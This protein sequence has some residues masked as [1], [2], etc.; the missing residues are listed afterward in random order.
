MLPTGR[1]R[2][3]RR[4]HFAAV[5]GAFAFTWF[6]AGC[7]DP[8]APVFDS[9]TTEEP[10]TPP[11]AFGVASTSPSNGEQDVARNRPIRITL[12]AAA[13]VPSL[14]SA[15]TVTGASGV[16]S[17]DSASR[18]AVFTPAGLYGPGSSISVVV[19]TALKDA[20]GRPLAADYSF[21]F[22]VSNDA[23][24]PQVVSTV[25]ANGAVDA[26]GIA[27][28]RAVFDE[29]L[30][31]TTVTTSSFTV[32]GADGGVSYDVAGRTAI[33]TPA[34]PLPLGTV[35]TASLSSGIR[36]LNGNP[37]A[38]GHRWSFTTEPD[39]YPPS[40]LFFDPLEG[41]G[42][43]SPGAPVLVRFDE[44][45][46]SAL[47]N[48]TNFTLRQ[49][50][51]GSVSG[52]VY[53]DTQEHSVSFT[54]YSDLEI[55]R[56][57]TARLA[58]G[59][60]RDLAG[61]TF[62]TELSWSFTTAADTTP[63]RVVSSSPANGAQGVA[64]SAGLAVVFNE[65]LDPGWVS[66]AFTVT[67]D[68][69]S[70]LPGS[71][72]Y[73]ASSRTATFRPYAEFALSTQYTL[74]V[75][76]AVRD[77]S[78]NRL[79]TP[80]VVSFRTE[81]DLI[82]PTVTGFSPGPGD[83]LVG[84]NA[85]ATVTFSEPVD[86]LT[87]LT[88]FRVEGVD[89]GVVYDPLQRRATFTPHER[90]TPGRSYLARVTSGVVDRAGNAL[91]PPQTFTF[92]TVPAPQLVS[93]VTASAHQD[94]LL[95]FSPSGEG[96]AAWR[97][98]NGGN[99]VT[100]AAHH[101]A[102]AGWQ[103]EE[104]MAIGGGIPTLKSSGAQATLGGTYGLRFND[105]G[106]GW[107][108]TEGFDTA[109]PIPGP[110]GFL[111]LRREGGGLT[112]TVLSNGVQTAPELLEGGAPQYWA[113]ATRTGYAIVYLSDG[114]ISGR[115]FAGGSWSAPSVLGTTLLADGGTRSLL[116]LKL[117][118][119]GTGLVAAWT[120][121]EAGDFRV[122]LVTH[123]GIAWS[124]AQEFG[125]SQS[126]DSALA[127]SE[128]THL[129][130]LQS[131]FTF[132]PPQ[133]L[134]HRGGAW[135]DA[136]SVPINGYLDS[137]TLVASADRYAALTY[138]SALVFLDGGW[139]GAT[140]LPDRVGPFAVQQ[141]VGNEVGFSVVF[142]ND[143]GLS[144][145]RY[146]DGAWG[147]DVV[148]ATASHPLEEFSLLGAGR[149]LVLGWEGDDNVHVRKTSGGAWQPPVTLPT[150]S[151]AGTVDAPE[152]VGD[153]AGRAAAVWGQWAGRKRGLYGNVFD[154]A[155]WGT[156]FLLAAE[157]NAV[158]VGSNGSSFLFA[159]GERVVND[160]FQIATRRFTQSLQPLVQIPTD[161]G[162]YPVDLE[163]AS[164]GTG[165][166]VAWADSRAVSAAISED[167]VSFGPKAHVIL[168]DH[169][170]VKLASNG[171]TYGA[172]VR[173]YAGSILS[174]VLHDG[175]QWGAATSFGSTSDDFDFAGAPAGYAVLWG[176]WLSSSTGSVA[177]SPGAG[178][179]WDIRSLAGS[180][181]VGPG[182][183]TRV[184]SGLFAFQR[185][186]QGARYVPITSAGIGTIGTLSP[187]PYFSDVASIGGGFAFL[188]GTYDRQ[189]VSL[190]AR[191]SATL[192]ALSPLGLI[193]DHDATIDEAR[194]RANYDH[195][196]VSWLE[197]DPLRVG[198]LWVQ[199]GL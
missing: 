77:A 1:D 148:L 150:R 73:S 170:T 86:P 59:A 40:V 114:A 182:R 147:T 187:D 185:S 139:G 196:L 192:P 108:S 87:V 66:G 14:S 144:E 83:R 107:S 157:G 115:V 33:F 143:G 162:F 161:A 103:P 41:A 11:A 21:G 57:Y 160:T 145:R 60:V 65:A 120:T 198:R 184:G 82:P 117:S 53:V 97:V 152:V 63:P 134:L 149:E 96:Y 129:L 50:D 169:E 54:P 127:S 109:D 156:P 36:D 177:F 52:S 78:G 155:S 119:G 38:G 42:N 128:T 111:F 6:G 153:S 37:L 89:G 112:A 9:G 55:G 166:A 135:S 100:V 159:Y 158:S 102:D 28:L 189:L 23:T 141:L 12:N 3:M 167:G 4:S 104:V 142:S 91:S 93:G 137:T 101:V 133:Y 81:A 154:G 35:V 174:T 31:P 75:S 27:P 116:N 178:A 79:A 39:V 64:T 110:N 17:W 126:F 26:G 43:A 123:D 16:I 190:G 20:A 168:G 10:P 183:L 175:G 138:R 151:Y 67:W 51:G 146:Q 105:G 140:V 99:G 180:N 94:L 98:F 18:T 181:G 61:N 84:L 56:R 199:T 194:L 90:L 69:G 80:Y 44:P 25:P 29:P 71:T 163:V 13:D 197:S 113:A 106:G 70:E 131:G 68:G 19:G 195:L 62:P 92:R 45:I 15:L 165:Y 122:H 95:A 2:Q 171:T 48:N 32:S 179:V 191:Y 173:S 49:V 164:N 7:G 172:A 22:T 188:I 72:S 24:G 58:Y 76:T 88:S 118:A 46:Q 186:N 130:L 193:E 74:T 47:L 5:L 121:Y 30:D 85:I 132:A 124:P 34:R 125:P 8:A 136:G 176:P